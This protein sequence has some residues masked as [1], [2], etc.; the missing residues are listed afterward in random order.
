MVRFCLGPGV[1]PIQVL[2]VLLVRV[3]DKFDLLVELGK[4]IL[5]VGVIVDTAPVRE[6]RLVI[7]SWICEFNEVPLADTVAEFGSLVLI[8]RFGLFGWYDGWLV[9]VVL[10]DQA[11]DFA[12]NALRTLY[13][14]N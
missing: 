1:V 2:V 3:V 6:L 7:A 14:L 13:G 9:S 12:V 10:A 11:P 5:F 4:G 8:D